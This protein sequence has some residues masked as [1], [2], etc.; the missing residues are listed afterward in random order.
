[1]ITFFIITEQ[2]CRHQAALRSRSQPDR[3]TWGEENGQPPED[4]LEQDLGHELD[5]DGDQIDHGRGE[6]D[7]SFAH[8]VDVKKPA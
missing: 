3:V 2:M 6:L 1:M 5:H 4:R 7:T 8:F